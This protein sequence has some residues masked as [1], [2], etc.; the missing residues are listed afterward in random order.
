M[1]KKLNWIES[2]IVNNIYKYNGR[3]FL[4]RPDA[5]RKKVLVLMNRSLLPE[6]SDWECLCPGSK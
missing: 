3:G 5:D 4:M 1:N 6:G 2:K